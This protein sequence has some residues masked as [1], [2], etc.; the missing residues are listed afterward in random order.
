M[1][2]RLLILALLVFGCDDGTSGQETEDAA[3]LP[4]TGPTPDALPV[5]GGP[6]D[7]QPDTPVAMDRDGDGVPD[8]QDN[9]PDEPNPDQS[10]RD[11]D[12]AGDACDKQPDVANFSLRRGSMVFTGG[13]GV[14]ATRTTRGVSTAGQL[15]STGPQYRLRGGLAP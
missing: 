11:G 3:V 12:G 7:A 9:C 10:D 14:D 6:R 4:E 2:R 1:S 13:R 8:A 5:D 15:D